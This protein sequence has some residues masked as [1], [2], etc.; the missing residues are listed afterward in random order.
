[1]WSGTFASQQALYQGFAI[2]TAQPSSFQKQLSNTLA[3]V[4]AASAIMQ[5]NLS[6]SE[7]QQQPAVFFCCGS[8]L[9]SVKCLLVKHFACL[10][11]RKSLGISAW[12]L[13]L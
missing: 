12:P 13:C 2:V 4:T 9:V 3:S 11:F 5:A 6:L 8:G 7:C 1:M 10:Y